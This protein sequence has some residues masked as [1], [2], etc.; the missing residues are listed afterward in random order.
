MRNKIFDPPRINNDFFD[1]EKEQKQQKNHSTSN[2]E[3][4][5]LIAAFG[6]L[7]A[8]SPSIK[9]SL[10]YQASMPIRFAKFNAPFLLL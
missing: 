4:T 8:L 9:G 10:T 1:T 5:C 2:T 6:Y 3:M 7:L